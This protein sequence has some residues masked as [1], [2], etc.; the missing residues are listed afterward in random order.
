MNIDEFRAFVFLIII[1]RIL[2]L[3]N[4]SHFPLLLAKPLY[5]RS[6]QLFLRCGGRCFSSFMLKVPSDS[7][8]FGLV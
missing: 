6:P 7:F 4:E 8:C 5:N 1:R 3:P 2:R